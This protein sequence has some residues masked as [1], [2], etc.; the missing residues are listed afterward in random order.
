MNKKIDWSN[1]KE[2]IQALTL[3]GMLLSEAPDEIKDD[4]E[5]VMAALE[6]SGLVLGVEGANIEFAT[7]GLCRNALFF[8]T[9]VS[10]WCTC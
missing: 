8:I 5:S 6:Q 7:E 9:Q 4:K 10:W 1:K 3:D 2:V